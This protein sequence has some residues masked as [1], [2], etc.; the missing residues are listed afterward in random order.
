M[1]IELFVEILILAVGVYLAFFKSYFSEKGKSLALK[2][3]IEDLTRQ[4]E[5]VKNEFT[6]EQE[7]LKKDLQRALS[8]EVSYRDEER[9][10]LIQFHGKINEWMYSILEVG[11]SNYNKSNIDSLIETRK[12]NASFYATTGVTKSKVD[13][14]VE[15]KQLIKLTAKLY[16]VA[17]AFHHWTDMEFLK[18]QQ[19]CESQ[20]SITERFMVIIKNLDQHK[21]LGEEMAKDEERLIKEAK[22]LFDNYMENLNEQYSKVTPVELEF[23]AA[24]KEYLRK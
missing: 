22:A 19:N 17:L 21:E 15:D 12:R 16:I 3:D 23:S 13:L 8:N 1:E 10:A 14:L 11:F 9:N 24:V 2:Q 4:V 7:F 5:A 18:L 6:K 20:K